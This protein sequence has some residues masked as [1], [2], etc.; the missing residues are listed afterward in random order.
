MTKRFDRKFDTLSRRQIAVGAMAGAALAAMTFSA[1]VLAADPLKIG[2]ITTLSGPGGYIGADARDGFQLAIDFEGGKLGGHPVSLVVEDDGLKP[3]Q[4]KQVADRFI[5]G[6]KIKLVTGIIFSNVAGA[7]V[8]DVL[9]AGGIYVSPN[10]G[11]SVFAGKMCHKNYFVT[12]WQNDSLHASAGANATRLGFKRAFVLAPNYQA[13]K[14]AIAGFKREFKGQIVGEVYTTLNATDY[15]AEIARIRASNADVV[16][17]FYPGGMGIAFSRQYAAS[18]IKTPM[19]VSAASV[20]ATILKAVGDPLVGVHV[21]SH[22]NADFDNPVNKKFVAEFVKKYNRQPTPYAAQAYDTALAIAS[23][24]KETNGSVDNT[25]AFRQAMLKANFQMTR[26]AFAFAKNQ[27][28]I[29]DWYALRVVKDASGKLEIKT[30]Q[31]IM[32]KHQ[33]PYGAACKL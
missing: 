5:K 11:P 24:L 6:E 15:A 3:G 25:E 18:G 29:Q 20:D 17:Q 10:A 12:S 2:F 13:G 32:D 26:G 27:H 1:P 9:D 21:S 14:D 4:G 31:K 16:F 23:A 7:V 8:P 30:Q 33:D 22:W 19:T 28:P